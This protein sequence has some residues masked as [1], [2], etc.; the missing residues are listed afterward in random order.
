MVK[1]GQMKYYSQQILH[2]LFKTVNSNI[3]KFQ[4]S[5]KIWKGSLET[6]VELAILYIC[7]GNPGIPEPIFLYHVSK[8]KQTKE[9]GSKDCLWTNIFIFLHDYYLFFF[10]F[11]AKCK[12]N[13]IKVCY[14]RL[15]FIKETQISTIS[16]IERRAKYYR[17]SY[18]DVTCAVRLYDCDIKKL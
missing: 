4:H 11:V 16:N 14:S 5:H 8:C 3:C 12:Y 7:V 1:E 17:A 9:Q 18:L 6:R 13:R 15:Q 10:L 2:L